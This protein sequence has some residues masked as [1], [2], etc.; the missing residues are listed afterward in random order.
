MYFPTTLSF[1]SNQQFPA[2]SRRIAIV[3]IGSN[4]IRYMEAEHSAVG[5]VFSR[6]EVYTTRLAEGLLATR[7]PLRSA[8]GPV[9]RRAAPAR[10]AGCGS[11]VPALCLCHQRRPRRAEP[12]IVCW[13]HSACNRHAGPSTCRQ[14]GGSLCLCRRDRRSWRAD[15]HRRGQH[16]GDVWRLPAKLPT[17]LRARQGSMRR[18]APRRDQAHDAGPFRRD[19]SSSP[20]CRRRNGRP[21]A[22]RP[23]PWPRCT[24]ILNNTTP[25]RSPDVR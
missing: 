18:P 22:A 8:H 24:C 10:R 17:G 1:M 16:A 15:R 12:G 14:R 5:P 2:A 21:S 11:W 6:K 23:P 4:S 7:L 19:V 20:R 9:A 3:D 13:A 25:Y